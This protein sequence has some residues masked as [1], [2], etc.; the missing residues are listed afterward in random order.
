M[1]NIEGLKLTEE[2]M[3]RILRKHQP[4]I[5]AIRGDLDLIQD[6]T[7]AAVVKALQGLVEYA[8]QHERIDPY[9]VEFLLEVHIQKAMEAAGIPMPI[10]FG[11]EE[12]DI[13]DF[14]MPTEQD[15]IIA[16]DATCEEPSLLRWGA[17]LLS[18][19]QELC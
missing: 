2:E 18:E 17:H 19:E 13:K 4:F 11:W 3:V 12:R 1:L 15:G 14:Y 5:F 7:D 6:A 9:T 16:R 8:N 10:G